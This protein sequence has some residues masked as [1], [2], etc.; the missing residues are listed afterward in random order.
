M[1][2]TDLTMNEFSPDMYC[3]GAVFG[4]SGFSYGKVRE[5]L[6]HFGKLVRDKTLETVAYDNPE[7]SQECHELKDDIRLKI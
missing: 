1:I 5:M 3:E 7:V 4:D 6:T 2:H